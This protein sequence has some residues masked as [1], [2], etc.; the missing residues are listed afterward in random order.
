MARQFA[1]VSLAESREEQCEGACRLLQLNSM[2]QRV[3]TLEKL[4]SIG[5]CRHLS[6]LIV[7]ASP[8]LKRR[9][10]TS[11]WVASW[12]VRFLAIAS[13]AD[14]ECSTRTAARRRIALFHATTCYHPPPRRPDLLAAPTCLGVPRPLRRC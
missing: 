9:E 7:T 6:V 4:S 5:R 10:M 3:N 8:E 12:H 13:T 11:M 2:A 1:R 14:Q